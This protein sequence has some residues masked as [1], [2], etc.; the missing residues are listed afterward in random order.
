MPAGDAMALR[1]ALPKSLSSARVQSVA[2]PNEEGTW[3]HPRDMHGERAQTARAHE[4]N[5]RTGSDP[6]SGY[7]RISGL[8]RS[9]NIYSTTGYWWHHTRLAHFVLQSILYKATSHQLIGTVRLARRERISGSIV[10]E[11]V[12]TK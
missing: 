3:R 5:E 6:T 12:R 1:H 11:V 9:P 7:S 10:R 2:K 4:P 8:S